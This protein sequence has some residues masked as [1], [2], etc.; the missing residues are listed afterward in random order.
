M[1][2]RATIAL[3]LFVI[4]ENIV[5]SIVN[6]V[7]A[8]GFPIVACIAMGVFIATSFKDFN[9]L[10]LKNNMLTDELIALLRKSSDD[11]DNAHA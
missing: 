10:L 5:D 9:N 2:T 1:S 6:L 8:V 4:R 7:G 3:V 11:K